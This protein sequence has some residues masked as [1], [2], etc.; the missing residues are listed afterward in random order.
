[1]LVA[2]DDTE[3]RI[4]VR[5][6]GHARI[7]HPLASSGSGQ[8][9]QGMQERVAIAAG[10]FTAGRCPDGGWALAARLPLDQEETTAPRGPATVAV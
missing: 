3:V 9:L 7:R 4:E 6:D 5:D 2:D 8:G 10:E 1:V